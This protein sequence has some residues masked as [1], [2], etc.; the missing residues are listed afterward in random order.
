MIVTAIGFEIEDG[1]A[2]RRI[3]E[4]VMAISGA[5]A[6]TEILGSAA[7]YLENRSLKN[8][9][10]KELNKLVQ[11]EIEPLDNIKA[12]AGV[13]RKFIESHVKSMVSEYKQHKEAAK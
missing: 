9:S 10:H 7:K 3:K 13:K 1:T 2:D 11:K 6:K 5:T 12:P 8:V 4:P